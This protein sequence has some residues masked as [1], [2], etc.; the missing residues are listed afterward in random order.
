MFPPPEVAFQ[1][2]MVDPEHAWPK[3][4]G[5]LRGDSKA[6]LPFGPSSQLPQE[7]QAAATCSPLRLESCI[8]PTTG[9]G[10]CLFWASLRG[11]TLS[12]GRGT[13][14]WQGALVQPRD[15]CPP[16]RSATSGHWP[17]WDLMGRVLGPSKARGNSGMPQGIWDESCH[18]RLCSREGIHCGRLCDWTR[19]SASQGVA[20]GSVWPGRLPAI[21]ATKAGMSV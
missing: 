6:W 18:P 5:C 9:G 17:L 14:V 15:I 16:A 10:M 21:L 19:P 8:Q 12:W 20:E 2:N 1:P 13:A 11:R 3:G 7:L 4:T